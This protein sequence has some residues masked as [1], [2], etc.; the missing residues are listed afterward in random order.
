VEHSCAD[1]EGGK[2]T[3]HATHLQFLSP[4]GWLARRGFSQCPMLGFIFTFLVASTYMSR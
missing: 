3:A 2:A 4:M 1:H